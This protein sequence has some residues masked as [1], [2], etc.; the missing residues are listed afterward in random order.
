MPPVADTTT[1][2]L[3]PTHNGSVTTAVATT[4]VGANIVPLMVLE[5]HPLPSVTVKLYA[6]PA[7]TVKDPTVAP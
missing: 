2:P 3:P 6:A 1:V 5:V 4:A 7:A